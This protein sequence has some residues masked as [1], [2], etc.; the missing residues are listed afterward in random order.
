LVI[1][2]PTVGH[3]NSVAPVLS[4]TSLKVNDNEMDHSGKI[5]LSP[6]R[7][8]IRIDFLGINLNEPELVTYQ[9]KMDGFDNWSE[10]TRNTSVTYNNMTEGK[11]TFILNASSGDGAITNY[12]VLLSLIIKK[13]IWK[14]WWFYFIFI[15]VIFMLFYF[16]I[17]RRDYRFIAEKRILE[18]KVLERTHEIQFQKNEIEIQRDIIDE[19]N[20]SITASIKYASNIQ[21]AILP[22]IELI[23]RLFANNFILSRP[24]DIVSGD[25]YWLAEIDDKIVFAVADCTGHGVPGAFMSFLGIT[26]L[27]SLVN[28]QRLTQSDLIVTRLRERVAYSLQQGRT[29]ISTADGMD[30]ALCVLDLKKRKIQ[31]TGGMNNLIY[32]REGK[33]EVV[34]ADRFSVCA[35]SDFPGVF[36]LNE[37]EI[38]E[39]DMF[40]LCT[41]GFKDQFGGDFDKKYLIPQFYLTLLEIHKFTMSE[42][43]K[44][45][46]KKLD[47]WMKGGIQT[48]DI[49]VLGIRL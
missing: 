36:T 10:I 8:K 34:K 47:E 27:N 39:G 49:T 22:P 20:A 17:K 4:I 15:S 30:I 9:Y 37:L 19:K 31:F 13:P 35:E 14:N 46:E 32:V 26:L 11:Y 41:D 16:Y 18:E 44:I 6:G 3:T 23:N 28:I 38:K 24:K 45:L 7:Y 29:D 33:V 1:Y 48:D 40:Y 43:K 21:K 25:F 12:P 2:H 42:Q 5:I